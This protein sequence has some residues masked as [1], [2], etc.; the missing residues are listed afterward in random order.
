LQCKVPSYIQLEYKDILVN[1][2]SSFVLQ[3][4]SCGV[5]LKGQM[6]PT[7][8]ALP[9]ELARPPPAFVCM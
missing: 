2:N 6:L 9:G 4:R 5:T 1:T 7:T 3:A 8:A